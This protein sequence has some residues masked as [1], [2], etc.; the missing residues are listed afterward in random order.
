MWRGALS[1]WWKGS[2]RRCRQGRHAVVQRAVSPAQTGGRG[3]GAVDVVE[4]ILDG[5][6]Q[7]PPQGKSRGH[8]GG[9]GAA[10]AV[11]GSSNEARS[12]IVPDALGGG[13]HV[14]HLVAGEMATL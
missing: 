11:G 10:G 13:Q 1:D 5:A 7:R 12:A 4:G 9:E 2:L 3:D 8:R 6:L 14:D